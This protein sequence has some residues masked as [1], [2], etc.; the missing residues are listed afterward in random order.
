MR[1]MRLREH[2]MEVIGTK[3]LFHIRLVTNRLLLKKLLTDLGLIA[4][5]VKSEDRLT[6]VFF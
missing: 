6:E 2:D 5:S 3:I 4:P 1:V